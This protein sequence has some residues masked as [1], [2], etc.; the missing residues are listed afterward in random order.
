MILCTSDG[1]AKIL[2]G[3]QVHCTKKAPLWNPQKEN[4]EIEKCILKSLFESSSFSPFKSSFIQALNRI[5]QFCKTL[6]IMR[7]LGG[8]MGVFWSCCWVSAFI[9]CMIWFMTVSE[10]VHIEAKIT[11]S[12]CFL[13]PLCIQSN[14]NK[15]PLVWSLF[16]C[17]HRNKFL[18]DH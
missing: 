4:K 3:K 7:E 6:A 11:V 15:W 8:G 14:Y 16:W 1:D 9:N 10:S 17:F 13:G 2:V 12:Q 18:A 5:N